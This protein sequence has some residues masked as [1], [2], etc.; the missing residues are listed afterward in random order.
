MDGYFHYI[1]QNAV[2]KQNKNQFGNIKHK[3][4]P[5]GVGTLFS[6]PHLRNVLPPK[7]ITTG[8][9]ERTFRTISFSVSYRLFPEDNYWTNI[10]HFVARVNEIEN[11]SNRLNSIN[12]F[13]II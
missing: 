3:Y 9:R 5:P 10:D 7:Q 4:F 1:S 2:N 8:N 13:Q 6:L 11:K 12:M